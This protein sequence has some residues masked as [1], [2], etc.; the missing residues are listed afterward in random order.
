MQIVRIFTEVWIGR[1]P[2]A[3]SPAE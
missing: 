1:F 2:A 3:E